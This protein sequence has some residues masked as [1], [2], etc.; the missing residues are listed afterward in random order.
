MSGTE[1]VAENIYMIDDHL[2]S[3]TEFGSVYLI[4]EDK[5][6][7]IDTGPT[8]SAG[9]VLDGLKELGVSPGDIDY[10]VIT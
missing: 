4:D 7:L 8:P 1:E 2:Y 10:I 6:A 3:M 9:F 5:K